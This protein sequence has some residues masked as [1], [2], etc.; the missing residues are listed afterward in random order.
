MTIAILS[1]GAH[2]T[3]INSLESH[4]I[5]GL[6]DDEK[7]IY[8]QEM[9]DKDIEIAQSYGYKSIGSSQN[10]GIGPA[11]AELVREAKGE[12]F[13]FLENDWMLIEPP[14]NQIKSGQYLLKERIIDVARFRHRRIPG[15]PLW[16]SQFAGHE[17]DR[18]QFLLDAIHWRDNTE[19][20]EFHPTIQN[21]GNW[22]FTSSANANW[23]NNPTMFRT[24]WL[25][26]YMLPWLTGDVER[27]IEDWWQE[28]DFSVAQSN[29]LFTHNRLD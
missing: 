8:F 16:S 24:E 9:S 4:K 27:G 7:I 23:T 5:F 10:I 2:R 28:Q 14:Q 12:F 1:W 26:E 29:G 19:M 6:D 18:P 25:R 22:H 15:H 17:M 3:L 13:L 20:L 11:Y 21:Y